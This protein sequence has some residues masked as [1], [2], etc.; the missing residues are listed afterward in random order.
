MYTLSADGAVLVAQWRALPV[1]PWQVH[2]EAEAAD[3]T[4]SAMTEGWLATSAL[5][6]PQRTADQTW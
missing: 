1:Q 5:T 3:R 4:T 2:V 6:L